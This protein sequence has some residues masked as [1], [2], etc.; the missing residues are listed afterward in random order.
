MQL[1]MKASQLQPLRP[2]GSIRGRLVVQARRLSERPR[3]RAMAATSRGEG[4]VSAT[5]AVAGI[6]NEDPERSLCVGGSEFSQRTS[7]GIYVICPCRSSHVAC[8]CECDTRSHVPAALRR[9]TRH[10]RVVLKARAWT[11]MLRPA[12]T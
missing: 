7:G 12:C 5:G 10:R 9:S 3:S 2:I 8:V 4:L 1:E 6:P 11:V